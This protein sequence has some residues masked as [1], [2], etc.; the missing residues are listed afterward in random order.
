MS[1]NKQEDS[2]ERQRSQITP[3]ADHKGYEV[4]REYLD[5]GIAGDQ[6]GKR[7][8]FVQLL[9]DAER[10]HFDVILCDDKDRFSRADSI[11]QGEIIA[12]LRRAGVRLETVAQGPIDWNSF[13]GRLQDAMLQE[14]KNAESKT[15]SYRVMTDFLRRAKGGEWVSALAPYGYRVEKVDGKRKL[16]P[17]PHEAKI[18][19]WMFDQVAKRG[20]SVG[21]LAEELT[22]S[23]VQLPRQK[24]AGRRVQEPRPAWYKATVRKILHNRAYVGDTAW[25]R[26]HG[27][28]YSEFDGEQVVRHDRKRGRRKHDD[29]QMIVV[30]A[31]HEPLVDRD[32]FQRVAELLVDNRKFTTPLK[33]Y[34][35]GFYFSRLLVCSRC[36][37]YMVGRRYQKD[38]AVKSYMCAGYF[39]IG[40]YFC[41]VHTTQEKPVLDRVIGAVQDYLF[42]RL[43]DLRTELN[44]EIDAARGVSDDEL[45]GRRA[46]V[47]ELDRAIT[48]GEKNLLAVPQDTAADRDLW[49]SLLNRLRGMRD[50]RAARQAELD[51]L[52]KGTAVTDREALIREAEAALWALRDS[53][54]SADPAEV[55]TA[56]RE[57]V[58]RVELS[59]TYEVHGKRELSRLN[60]GIIYLRSQVGGTTH[61]ETSGT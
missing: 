20:R 42:A 3:Y 24:G 11:D 4:V 34:E 19:R 47:Q 31:T 15:I 10:G 27:G 33:P 35:E 49:A 46:A 53:L 40:K 8:Q 21:W 58:D 59:F 16:I 13:A 48:Q 9:K 52:E 60:R 54:R 61:S 44:R 38:R 23:S 57:L 1:T 36:G 28:G 56:L 5:E 32:T 30:S 43:A 29:A 17:E 55:R 22:A 51:G 6:L 50:D 25:N 7:K 18:V 45:A 37:H 12:P 14:F 26:Q 39:R 41:K 2:P